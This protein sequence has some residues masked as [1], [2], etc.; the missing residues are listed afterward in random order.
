[1]IMNDITLEGFMTGCYLKRPIL[2]IL[3]VLL[4]FVT[5]AE[6][7][8]ARRDVV[9]YRDF[10]FPKYHGMRLSYCSED[11]DVCGMELASKYCGLMGYDK[12]SKMMI[13]HNV[14]LTRFPASNNSSPISPNSSFTTNAGIGKIAGRLS[15]LAKVLVKTLLVAGFG[16]VPLIAP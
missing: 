14:G 11:H 1:M 15:T 5:F 7:Q 8:D 10:W 2:L 6:G 3:L 12:A 13:E 9:G 4:P 16:A